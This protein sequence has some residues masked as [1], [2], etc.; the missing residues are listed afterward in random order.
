MVIFLITMAIITAIFLILV[1]LVQNS[2][3]GGLSSEFGGSNTNQL[4]GVKKTNNL[5]EQITWGLAI[6]MIVL[7]FGTTLFFGHKKQARGS[8]S[9]NIERAKE[10]DFIQESESPAMEEETTSTA[11]PDMDS[12]TETQE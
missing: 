8:L 12:D 6:T 7:I 3:G 5:L 11:S 2:K 4:M 9:P 1:V 10:K